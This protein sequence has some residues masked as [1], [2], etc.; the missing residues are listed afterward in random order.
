MI[1]KNNKGKEKNFKI[2]F[3]AIKDGNKY[4]VYKDVTSDNIYGGKYDN[5]KLIVLNGDEIEYLNKIIEKL[6]G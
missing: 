1:L 5:N 3:E 4:V 6:N 2:L